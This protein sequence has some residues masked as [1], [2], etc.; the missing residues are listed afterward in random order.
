MLNHAEYDALDEAERA[1]L[2]M[3]RHKNAEVFLAALNATEPLT[4]KD[5][6]IRASYAQARN[7]AL[8]GICSTLNRVTT[9]DSEETVVL[10]TILQSAARLWMEI[11]SQRYRLFVIVP[12]EAKDVLRIGRGDVNHL[13]FV[14]KPDLQR[15]GTASGANARQGQSISG[16]KRQVEIYPS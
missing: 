2:N 4:E 6:A 1:D 12:A 15:F 13:Q 10:D 8:E 3:W 5:Q 14:V 11:S 9:L 16:W 7:A